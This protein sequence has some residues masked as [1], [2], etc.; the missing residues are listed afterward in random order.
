MWHPLEAVGQDLRFG[1]RQLRKSPAFAAVAILTLALGIG[2]NTAVYSVMDAVLL[3][4]LPVR[5]PQQLV[6]LHTSD[7]PGGQTGYGGTSMRMQ[8]YEALRK[9]NRVFS[10]L[11]AWVP[12]SAGG[13]VPA[14]IGAEP[15]EL[16]A[17]MVSGN[18]FS[19]L[20][21][22]AVRGRTFHLQ[23]EQEH[24]QIAVLSDA[25]WSRRFARDPAVLGSTLFL[26]GV[27]FTVVG[28]ARQGFVGLD[29][30]GPTDVWVPF[31]ISE[32][33]KPWGTPSG[34]TPYGN[35][36]TLYGSKWW[37]L[38]TVGR[39]QPNVNQQQA[40]AY[41]NP[42]FRRAALEGLNADDMSGHDKPPQLTFTDTRGMPGT[43]ESYDQPLRILMGMVVLV[44]AIACGNIA[45]LLVAR[46]ASRQREF[47]LRMALGGSR[48]QL[49]RLLL[50]ESTLLVA[51]GA[52]LGWLFAIWATGALAQW[53]LLERSLAPDA[54]VLVFTLAVS[55]I[56]GFAFSLTPLRSAVQA[57]A[58]LALK[59][60]NATSAQDPRS[61]RTGSVMIPLQ[62]AMCLVLL[63]GAGLLVRTL[64]NLQDLDLGLSASNLLVFGLTPQQYVHNDDEAVT[65]YRGLL[66]HM[67]ALPGVES[68]SLMRQRLG[69][70]W[71]SNTTAI[72]DGQ[73]PK[74]SG[75]PSMRW[76]SVGPGYFHLLRI[77]FLLGRDISEAD[78]GEAPP[79]VVINKTFADRYLPGINAI[80]HT[81]QIDRGAD[82]KSYT[83]V[84]VAANSKYTEV[85]EEQRPMAYFPYMQVKSI[86]SMTVE[87]RTV[88]NP[89]AFWPEVR[90]AMRE[91]APDL[92]LLEPMTQEQ[93]FSE[94]ISGDRLFARLAMFFGGLASLLVATGLYGTLA[95]KVVRRTPEIGVRMALGAQQMQVLW[96]V[97]RESL[98]FLLV[99][100]LLGLPAAAG[101]GRLLKASLFGLEPDDPLTFL[102]A[103]VGIAFVALA[104]SFVPARRASSV[105]PMLALRSE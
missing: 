3:R 37:F 47:S 97:L 63:V 61:R 25:Y 9:E 8:V 99:G 59:T 70:G 27:P 31:Q 39:L 28:I 105:D 2:A 101:V 80:G 89:Q 62:M 12:L 17:D 71:S 26:K 24:A 57:G 36:A 74:V 13:G 16:R 41:L 42:I 88:G 45:M 92:A 100:L 11:M 56:V 85:R 91:Y 22:P 5:D 76:N 18:F 4:S 55:V 54:R 35:T 65:F 7:F 86:L 95:Y 102:A 34:K 38:L 10:D 20:G 58:G 49:F 69:A 68:A 40:L 64:R 21:V 52:L 44:L 15:E 14:R 73:K 66:E 93:Q 79:V 75:W 30:G 32:E 83:I 43:R 6:Y 104:A 50:A 1:L 96:M 103:V 29:E 60:S 19:G 67:R 48:M 84:G 72:V 98:M 77:P 23:D 46:N 78:S 82:S 87:L 81:V 51:G 90:R 33:V 94:S 53:S